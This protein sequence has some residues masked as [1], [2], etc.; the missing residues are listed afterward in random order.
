MIE[1]QLRYLGGL[2]EVD[3]LVEDG[4]RDINTD[5]GRWSIPIQFGAGFASE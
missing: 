3:W 4:L 5:S 2:S 1:T